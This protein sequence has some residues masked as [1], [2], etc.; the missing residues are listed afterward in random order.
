MIFLSV[1]SLWEMA[2][3]VNLG[4]LKLQRPFQTIK[5]DL[6]SHDFRILPLTFEDTIQY[7]TLA[8]HHRDPFDR[9]L[10]AQAEQEGLTLVSRDVEIQRYQVSHLAA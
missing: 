2:I 3:K 4:K 9:M 10:V 5:T 1:I 6:L 8:F 7:T